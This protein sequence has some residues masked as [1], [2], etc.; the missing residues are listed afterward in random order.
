MPKQ[1]TSIAQSARLTYELP[2]DVVEVHQDPET[3][4]QIIDYLDKA[5]DVVFQVAS[6][7]EVSVERGI[8][9]DFQQAVKLR[10]TADMTATGSQGGKAHGN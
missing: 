6:S 4:D 8:A 3:K 5:R 9:Q 10:A 2:E 1:E 7:E